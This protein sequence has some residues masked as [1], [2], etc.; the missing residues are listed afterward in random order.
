MS[1]DA[2]F[3][4]MSDAHAPFATIWNNG[5]LHTHRSFVTSKP[6]HSPGRGQW[7]ISSPSSDVAPQPAP[8]L[9][10]SIKQN[11]CDVPCL[12]AT[13]C[14]QRTAVDCPSGSLTCPT[15]SRA[16]SG[17]RSLDGSLSP[18]DVPNGGA[19][20]PIDRMVYEKNALDG[21][22]LPSA[23]EAAVGMLRI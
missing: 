13:G 14:H 18:G 9:S 4:S 8:H 19:S 23:R 17:D 22:A 7:P 21:T 16:D 3:H 11:W 2:S 15:A 5:V 20:S 1:G 10:T 12:R 6:E